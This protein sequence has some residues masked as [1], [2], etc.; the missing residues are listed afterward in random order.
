MILKK[1]LVLYFVINMTNPTF[2]FK[3]EKKNNNKTKI[4]KLIYL[5]IYFRNLIFLNRFNHCMKL[6]HLFIK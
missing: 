2:L 3:L 6:F 5:Y 1:V 4:D